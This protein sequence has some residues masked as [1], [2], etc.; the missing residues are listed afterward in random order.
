MV[1]SSGS[2]RSAAASAPA[3]SP[4]TQRACSLRIQY[5]QAAMHK[6][7]SASRCR[8]NAASS[9]IGPSS[10]LPSTGVSPRRLRTRWSWVVM[11]SAIRPNFARTT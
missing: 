7:G 5:Q 11:M 10:K 6:P 2:A 8:S 4:A 3:T 9:K 1:Q